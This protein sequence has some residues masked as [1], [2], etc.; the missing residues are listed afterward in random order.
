VT[1]RPGTANLTAMLAA[2]EAL[3][4]AL[5]LEPAPVR[6][7]AVTLGLMDTPLLHTPYGVE[8]DT[9]VRNVAAV[10]PGRRVGTADEVAQVVLMLRII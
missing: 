1:P 8:R 10:L 3:A 7:N 2:V 4:P 6:L 5:A 9:I